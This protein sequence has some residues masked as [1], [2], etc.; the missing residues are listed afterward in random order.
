ML[1]IVIRPNAA[2]DLEE[3]IDYY[4]LQAFPEVAERFVQEFE[5]VCALL[6]ERP[7]IGSRRFAHL[8][9]GG[10]RTWSLDRFPFRVFYLV[11]DGTLQIVAVDHE[12]RDVSSSGFLRRPL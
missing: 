12:R 3:A 1:S 7:G 8:M 10:L 2:A 6:A 4:T 9:P 11:E 5:N